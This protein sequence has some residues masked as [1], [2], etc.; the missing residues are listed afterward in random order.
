MFSP[1]CVLEMSDVCFFVGGWGCGGGG[2]V[3]MRV[4]HF[5]LY[6]FLFCERT[7][8]ESLIQFV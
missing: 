3:V 6:I 4:K 5:Y 8:D 7:V 2:G 1:V